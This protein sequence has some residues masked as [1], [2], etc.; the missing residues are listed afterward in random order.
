MPSSMR[1]FPD[2][3]AA[4]RPTRTEGE[5]APHF[6]PA[7]RKP[8]RMT[9][10]GRRA[11]IIGT[12]GVVLALALGLALHAMR[13]TIVFFR[14][15]S[16]IAA[17]PKP[18]VRV[19]LGGLV[20]TGSVVRGPEQRIDFAVTDGA[21]SVK[22]QYKGLLPDLFREGQGVVTEGAIDQTGLFLAST[23]LARHDETYMPREV[24]DALKAQGRWQEGGAKAAP[25]QTSQR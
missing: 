16:E 13:D 25:R 24:V 4:P 9:R 19:R 12:S 15:P 1:P 11:A 18:G 3:T 22:V 14:S 20:E 17:A 21:A 5:Y 7:G 10:R 8:S 2:G 23:V 6:G